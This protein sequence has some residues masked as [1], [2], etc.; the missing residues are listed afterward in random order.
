MK[1]LRAKHVEG[2]LKGGP[3]QVPRSPPLKHTTATMQ[4]W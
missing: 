3:S 4:P 2:A 1:N